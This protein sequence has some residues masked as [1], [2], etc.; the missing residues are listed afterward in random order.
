M[1]LRGVTG[2]VMGGVIA[3]D[4][5]GRGIRTWCG[6][7]R[8]KGTLQMSM[9]PEFEARVMRNLLFFQ[10]VFYLGNVYLW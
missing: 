3:G 7:E 5:R 9:L 10:C 2:G 1:A 8:R 6:L 4:C